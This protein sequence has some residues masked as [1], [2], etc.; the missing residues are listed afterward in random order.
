MA[1]S[2]CSSNAKTPENSNAIPAEQNQNAIQ[3]G[4]KTIGSSE[5]KILLDKQKDIVVLD[6]RTPEEYAA[7]HLKNAVLLNK[8]DP[9]FAAKLKAFDRNKTYLIYCAVGGRSGQTAS[10]MESLG[11]KNIFDAT[12][13][14]EKLKNAGA[15]VE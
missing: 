10:M 11:F 14:F 1:F 9:D 8:Y 15:P 3:N 13:G 2:S 5:T 4:A 6:V 12:E 7:G